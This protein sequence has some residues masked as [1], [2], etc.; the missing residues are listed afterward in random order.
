MQ[1][2]NQPDHS[3]IRLMAGRG[4]YQPLI[5][6]VRNHIYDFFK[7]T[8]LRASSAHASDELTAVLWWLSSGLCKTIDVYGMAFPQYGEKRSRAY[9]STA[10]YDTGSSVPWPGPSVPAPN[11]ALEMYA[12]HAAMKEGLLC[13]HTH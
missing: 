5:N 6:G 13:V 8:K 1:V 12:L 11:A 3:P 10:S 4:K 7:G 9:W 2:I